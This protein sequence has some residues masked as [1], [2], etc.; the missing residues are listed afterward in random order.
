MSNRI[1]S[2]R[3]KHHLTQKQ[4][5]DILEIERSSVA[6]YETGAAVPSAPVLV[7]LS[8]YFSVPTDLFL[9]DA[10][11]PENHSV[12]VLGYAAGGNPIYA[13]EDILGYEEID[14]GTKEDYFALKLKG[15]SMQP[16]IFD[17]D[18]MI[19]K[20]QNSAQNGEIAV[21]LIGR[22]E[23]TVKQFKKTREGIFLIPLN[24]AYQ[25]VFYTYAETSTLPVEIL[26][27]VVEIRVKL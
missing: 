10:D 11:P 7:K 6:K 15:N 9:K 23:T 20:R 3:I 26:G 19:V 27:R 5:A 2:L 14:Y 4:L 18:T 12:P 25:P 16:R 13:Y 21:F 1:K 24:S 8:D 22:E 17:G